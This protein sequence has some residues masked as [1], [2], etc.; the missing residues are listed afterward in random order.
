MNRRRLSMEMIERIASGEA[1]GGSRSG[2]VFIFVVSLVVL[3]LALCI[4]RSFLLPLAWAVV[5]A[6]ATWPLYRRFA[7]RWPR[8]FAAN[9]TPLVFT[10]L[11]TLFVL[12]P[13]G[14]AFITIGAQAQVWAREVAFAEQYGLAPPIW[15]A[16]IPL[17][18][19]WLVN[20]WNAVLGT[21]GGVT[22]LLQSAE[23][24]SMI[25]RGASLGG[26]VLRHTAIIAFTI[27]AL[28]F[29]YRGGEPLAARTLQIVHQ[30][31]GPRGDRYFRQAALSIRATLGGMLVVSL[32]DGVLIGLAYEIAHVPSAAA[33]GAITGL[34]AMIPFV[35]YLA[36]AGVALVLI[37]KGAGAAALAVFAWGIFV[38]FVA[39]KLV[40]PALLANTT[41]L[42]FFWALLG[43]LGGLAAFGL[44]GLFIGPAILALAAAIWRDSLDEVPHIDAGT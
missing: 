35:A 28:F 15:L 33:W 11:I 10:A 1:A 12:G 14:F 3:V 9:G 8:R 16:A 43:S 34:L 41:R 20:H 24:A 30:K 6:L 37:A 4:L 7:A 25:G 26:F 22:G 29:L 21:P 5:L 42:G 40:L 36:V 39:D 38:V 13:F 31:L 27:L 2:H 17:A 18:G 19:S 32:I 44:L 23:S